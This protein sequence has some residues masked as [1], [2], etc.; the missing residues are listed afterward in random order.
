M[1]GG[2]AA[3]ATPKS[4]MSRQDVLLAS[5][6]L[7]YTAH[8]EHLGVMAQVVR[9][10]KPYVSLR[11]LDWLVT[12]YAKKKNITYV[13]D[14]E[15]GPAAFN[16]HLE[17]KSQLR[18]YSKRFFDP[19]RRRGRV[20]F[21]PRKTTVGQLNFFRWAILNGVV[22]Y[23]A[24]HAKEIEADMIRSKR[25]RMPTECDKKARRRELSRGPK[26]CKTPLTVIIRF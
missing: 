3:G 12:N 4:I 17:Y 1:Q 20:A 9:K 24:D 14:R 21:G 7:F 6:R 10:S 16:M 11:I 18:A 22:A 8:P 26:T 25:D 13:V 15:D 19:F 2:G 5:L 23:G